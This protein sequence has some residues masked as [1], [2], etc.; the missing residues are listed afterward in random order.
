MAIRIPIITD[1]QDKGIKDAKKAF[2]DF[3]ASVANAEGGLG[4][5]KAGSKSIMDSVGAN[6]AG[7]AVAG[8]FEPGHPWRDAALH[9]IFLGF[10]FSMV[11]GHAPIIFPAVMRVKIPYS[12][13]FYLPLIVLHLSLAWRVTGSLSD[14]WLLR[15]SGGLINGVSL[16]LF[17]LTLLFTVVRAAS[18]RKEVS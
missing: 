10:V 13:L 12:P 15:Q 5:F 1:L 14:V 9:A 8:G 16:A 4:K 3:K 18:Q 2:G 17:I 6:A 7:F 11:I